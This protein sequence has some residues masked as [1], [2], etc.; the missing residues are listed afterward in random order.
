MINLRIVIIGTCS[1]G[2]TTLALEL[3]KVTNLTY[4]EEGARNLYLQLSNQ[5]NWNQEDPLCQLALQYKIYSLKVEQELSSYSKGF[6][7]DRSYL[8]NFMYYLYYCN[9]VIEKD[10]MTLFESWS[11]E[12]MKIY[13]HIF[14]LKLDSIPYVKDFIRTETY[15]CALMYETIIQGLIDRWTIPVILITAKNLQDRVN[16]V[17]TNLNLMDKI[18]SNLRSTPITFRERIIKKIPLDL[19]RKSVEGTL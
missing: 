5:D 10:S 8:D 13:T 19:S 3:A 16:F 2:K 9:S 7:A 11:R 14:I 18:D 12:A 6:V 17:L 4:I 15:S 1:T